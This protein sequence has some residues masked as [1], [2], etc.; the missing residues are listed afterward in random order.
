MPRWLF[1]M[2]IGLGQ[3][4]VGCKG[5]DHHQGSHAVSVLVGTL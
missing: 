4:G 3:E 2:I 5:W 1:Q